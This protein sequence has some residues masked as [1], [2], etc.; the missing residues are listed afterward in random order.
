MGVSGSDYTAQVQG[1]LFDGEERERQ[2]RVD[3]VAD[4]I[5]EKFGTGAL[6]RGSS[7]RGEDPRRC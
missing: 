2:G 7:L 4:Q 6:R 1:L 3:V 5:K